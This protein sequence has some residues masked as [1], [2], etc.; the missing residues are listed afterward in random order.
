MSRN[1]N[2]DV[3]M[4]GPDLPALPPGWCWATLAEIA[5]ID[6]GITKDQKRERT[7]TMREVPYLRVA[8]V[9][10]GY[11]N[12]EEIK[13][14]FADADELDA[15]RLR[16]GDV[17]F[18]EGGDRD[19][20]G[21]GWV[22]NEEIEDCIHQNHIFRARP[23]PGLVEP[24]FISFHGNFFG[25]DWFTR[26]GKQTT[27]LASI[28][29]GVLSRFPV[30]LAPLNEQRRIVAKIEELLSDLDAGVAALERTKAKLKRYRAAVLK[31]AVEGRLTAEWRAQHPATEPASK[32]LDRIL[33]ERRQRWEADQEAKYKA[34]GKT[35]PKGWR[36]KYVEPTPPDTAPSPWLPKG[37]CWASLSQ[38]V[39]ISSGEA[40]KKHEYSASGLRLLQI[41][42]VGFGETLWEQQNWLPIS[43][44]ITHAELA[45]KADDIVLALNRPI[46]GNLL[47]VARVTVRDLPAIL[48]QRVARLRP[49]F[50]E[51]TPYLF[52]CLLAPQM[53][54]SVR[55]RLQGTDQ[56]YLNTSLLPQIPVVVA[57]LG[58]QQQI[59][60]EVEQ[61]L[62]VISAAEQQI[63]RDLLRANRLRQ[64]ILKRA[65]EGKLVPQDPRDEPASVLLER[66]RATRLSTPLDR[67]GNVEDNAQRRTAGKGRQFRRTNRAEQ[68]GKP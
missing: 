53:M 58:E 34:A 10:R 24:K 21:R 65:F 62:S 28:N 42:N 60:T 44:A 55:S 13:T 36:E 20:L 31:A 2:N 64:S 59:V 41:A 19:K 27:N 3:E 4:V 17:L 6:G 54:Y 57:P 38:L 67:N 40:F 61:R 45:M 22:W 25:Q 35:P 66:I 14:I 48:Y 1:R 37:W 12:L 30:P 16:K 63:E 11:L 56:P 15:L 33:A 46:L 43:Y 29:K 18:T 32:L 51:A 23:C 50:I 8:N 47:K 5:A 49:A 39:L 68:G 7:P 26:T 52:L 9:Q